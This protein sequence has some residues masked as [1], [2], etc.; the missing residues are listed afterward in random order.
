MRALLTILAL[1]FV[2]GCDETEHSNFHPDFGIGALPIGTACAPDTPPT[3]EC[4]YWPQFHC[5]AAGVCAATCRAGDGDGGGADC[6]S[7]SACVGANDLGV[8]ECVAE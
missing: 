1:L 2:G 5:S 7:G 3:S 4:G 8:G 6:P